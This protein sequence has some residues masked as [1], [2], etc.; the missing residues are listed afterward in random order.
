[1]DA[2]LKKILRSLSLE[3]RHLL[4]GRYDEQGKLI[5]GDLE[6]ELNRLGIWRDRPPKPISE[7]PH[8]KEEEKQARQIIDA[9]ISYRAGAGISQND[10]VEEFI[11][12]S[13]YTWANRLFALRCMEA[14]GIIDPVILQ[15]ETY[16]GRSMVHHRFSQLHPNLCTGEDDG[17]YS[18]LF[19]E[20]QRRSEELPDLFNPD[21]PAVKLRPSVT[22]L[23]RCINLLSGNL[24]ANGG[25]AT[26]E[27]F[28]A[29]DAFGW[30]YQYWNLEEKDRVFE[31]VRTKKG[32]KIEGK[33]IIPAT[34]IYTEDYM[35]KFLV[36]NSLGATWMMMHPESKLSASWEYYV[37]DADRTPNDKKPISEVTFLD[38]ACGSGHFL[39]EAFD[40]FYQ[41]YKD[42]GRIRDPSAICSSILNNN[43]FGIDIDE[44]AVQITKAVLLMKAAEKV[45]ET[46]QSQLSGKAL[47]SFH[48]HIIATNIR[49]PK[50]KDQ[51]EAFL[52]KHPDDA[53]MKPAL[54]TVLE[55][56]QN[57][58][59]LGSLVQIEEPVEKELRALK[60]KL[61]G[62][63]TFTGTLTGQTTFRGG[64]RETDWLQW[65]RDVI[66]RL[67]SHFQEAAQKATPSESFF[68]H[69][70][71]KG[72]ALFDL[73]SQRYDVVSA[74]PP[75]MGSGNMGEWLKRY[76]EAHYP[77]GKRDLFAAFILRNL[78][79]SETNGRVAMV[80]QQSWMFLKSYIELRNASIKSSKKST[81]N[82]YSGLLNQTTI[83]TIAHLGPHAFAEISGEVV[84]TALFSLSNCL[85]IKERRITFFRLIGG[86]CS[87]DKANDLRREIDNKSQ[88]IVFSKQQSV[89]IEIPDSPIVY[90]IPDKLITLLINEERFSE[91]FDIKRGIDTGN[92]KRHLRY[93][94]E[95]D[96]FSTKRWV[97]LSKG[98]GYSKWRGLEYYSLDWIN[99]ECIFSEN[100][101]ARLQNLNYYLRKGKCYSR[102][103]NGCLGVRSL[104]N[105]S[106][107]GG[108]G[109]GIFEKKEISPDIATILNTHFSTYVVRA[110][111]Q[112]LV[113][114]VEHVGRIPFVKNFIKEKNISILENINNNCTTLKEKITNDT[115]I[116]PYFNIDSLKFNHISSFGQFNDNKIENT[117]ISLIFEGF[118]ERFVLNVYSLE[119]ENT[120]RNILF[121]TGTQA[122]WHPLLINYDK[123]PIPIESLCKMNSD[124]LNYMNKI[125]R[126]ELTPDQFLNYK[127]HLQT[128]Y[129][130]GP[131][132]KI[133]IEENDTISSQEDEDSLVIG[134]RIPIPAETFIEELSQKME[135]H[136]ISLYWLLKE[137]IEKEGWRCLPEERRYTEDRFTVMILRLLG[138]RWPKQI[139]M[140]EP[141]PE[142]ADADGIIPITAG[143]GQPSLLDR[144]RERIAEEFP[145]GNVHEIE[146]EFEEIM[147]ITLERWLSSEFFK[148]HISQFKKRP[149]AWQLASVPS[150]GRGRGSRAQ[151]A[152]S[153]LVYYHKCDRDVLHKIRTQYVGDLISRYE[154]ELRTL[155]GR[156][157]LSGE[158]ST[159][160]VQLENWLTELREFAQKLDV[161][162]STGFSSDFL[163][164]V[165]NKEPL[166]KWTSRDG[167]S[168]HPT[169]KEEF[170]LQEQR[171]DP[172]INDGVRVNIAPLQKAGLL[173][174]DVIA[175]KDLEKAI[176]DRAEWR[177]DERRWCREGKL[178]KPGWWE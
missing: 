83:E 2:P 24:P 68:S 144:V 172:D 169:T 13:A 17:L 29:P 167:K 97:L 91:I 88:E 162:S 122:S 41:M 151:P 163:K 126:L 108:N 145:G 166:D 86:T 51:L 128:L 115:I 84:N 47:T 165:A 130:T 30:A 26:E 174:A 75:Y 142:W 106:V 1:M 48:D 14:R 161:V 90:W 148:H 152:F 177:A 54:L 113:F 101:G 8:L 12:E 10:A 11:R 23:K 114:Q 98:G 34:C 58:H 159:R 131:G 139:E 105:H 55:G 52:K 77:Q 134:A 50:T 100:P 155:E 63:T 117:I 56:L 175:K 43:L 40:L 66:S 81:I 92:D 25:A 123:M 67:K 171:Y 76:I 62:Q 125:Q 31:M 102:I 138:H 173:T 147:G 107:I 46:T 36:Q 59:E 18:T 39:I 124:I 20:F 153:C 121:E 178:P 143:T 49:L 149:I 22:A 87:D 9:Y 37:K 176:S 38:P 168:P 28:I 93:F 104:S 118:L 116:E 95:I 156:Q 74:N 60:E 65:R 141:V 103:A 111:S 27:V 42:E 146:R 21:S 79:F 160:K 57:V 16:G 133:Q 150:G 154:T 96:L 119:D 33:D 137:G 69:S 3:L 5:T 110:L 164:E 136:P 158:Q 53:P 129:E 61:G 135:I 82:K 89:F 109:P 99:R 78:Q 120:I 15:E 7:L 6:R 44:R 80:T 157:E 112:S 94:W 71:V 127:N 85:P 45:F 35:V 72:L 73:L 140:G 32:A 70:A 4:E 132:M 19:D 170:L 64:E